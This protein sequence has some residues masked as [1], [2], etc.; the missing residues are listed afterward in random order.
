M[1]RKK[2]KTTNSNTR[3]AIP[4]TLYLKIKNRMEDTDFKSVSEYVTYVL[5]EVISSMEEEEKSTADGDGVLNEEEE[6]IVKNRLR[7]LG[8]LD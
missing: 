5:T 6:E 4:K 1:V 8:Y 3:V 2:E 7:A